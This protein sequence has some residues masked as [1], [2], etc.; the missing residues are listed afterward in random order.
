MQLQPPPGLSRGNATFNRLL[1][2][3]AFIRKKQLQDE[4]EMNPS[5]DMIR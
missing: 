5:M 3:F 4:T 1:C 2:V